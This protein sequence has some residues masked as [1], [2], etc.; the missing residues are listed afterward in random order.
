M[1]MRRGG[2]PRWQPVNRDTRRRRSSGSSTEADDRIFAAL[3]QANS[4]RE[5]RQQQGSKPLSIEQRLKRRLAQEAQARKI[6]RLQAERDQQDRPRGPISAAEWRAKRAQEAQAKQVEQQRREQRRAGLTRYE[7]TVAP[8]PVQE[9]T[10][11]RIRRMPDRQGPSQ[12]ELDRQARERRRAIETTKYQLQEAEG[13]IRQLDG[14]VV[15][16]KQRAERLRRTASQM[17][18]AVESTRYLIDAQEAE[19]RSQ[20][21][22]KEADQER[23]RV[24]ALKEQLSNLGGV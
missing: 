1:N 5:R 7:R 18:N 6:A 3:D 24:A 20:R 15:G 17:S 22:K 2:E 19:N 9:A 13:F 10:E 4:N 14:E 21:K 11:P 23:A 8:K 12:R 16:Q